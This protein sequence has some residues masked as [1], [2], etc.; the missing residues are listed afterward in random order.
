M[1]DNELR[2]AAEA[3]V[4]RWDSIDWKAAPTA[5]VM[6]RLRNALS[7]P[8]KA[9]ESEP[10]P[11][12]VDEWLAPYVYGNTA[13]IGVYDLRAYINTL[14]A[15]HQAELAAKDAEI[16]RLKRLLKEA[17]DDLT[18]WGGYV[19]EYF[20]EKHKLDEDIQ[21]YRQAGSSR[22]ALGRGTDEEKQE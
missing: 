9:A 5:E 14:P 7:A 6:N 10:L 22:A 4:A 1:A 13:I 11:E 3:V 20:V 19:P 12:S 17:A 21:K 18:E 15:A 16:E 8:E 2:A